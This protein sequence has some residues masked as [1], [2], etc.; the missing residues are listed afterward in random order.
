[1]AKPVVPPKEKPI[2]AIKAPTTKGFTPEL[3]SVAPMNINPKTRKN[4][5]MASLNTL[6]AYERTAGIVLNIP[7]FASWDAVAFQ[8]AR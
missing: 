8:C 6:C 7:S 3:N 1:M 5:A 4:V 2:A